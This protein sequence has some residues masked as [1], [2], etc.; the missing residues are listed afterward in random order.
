MNELFGDYV[1]DA[2]QQRAGFPVWVKCADGM[3]GH[4]DGW[5][6]PGAMHVIHTD[7]KG[8]WAIT[9]MPDEHTLAV[10]RPHGGRYPQ[11]AEQWGMIRVGSF[12]PLDLVVKAL[13]LAVPPGSPPKPTSKRRGCPRCGPGCT[14]CKECCYHEAFCQPPEKKVQH[15]E[16]LAPPPR[17]LWNVDPVVEKPEPI[18]NHVSKTRRW[19]RLL[20]YGPTSGP[21]C[22]GSCSVFDDTAHKTHCG[23]V[24]QS[25]LENAYLVEA[26]NAITLRPKLARRL[27]YDWSI[28]FS[29]FA[30]RLFKN[31]T[32]LCVEV[33]DWVPVRDQP[34]EADDND[35]PFC[36]YSEHFP[37]VLWPSLVEKAYAK[38]STIRDHGVGGDT[39]NTGG[40]ESLGGGGRV[41]EALAD[42]TGGV[43]SSFSTRDVA[44]DRLFIYLYELQR[45]C[46]FV[47]R[48]HLIHC[49]KR[50]VQLDPFSHYS[51]NRAAHHEGQGFVQVF[52][53]SPTGVHTAGLDF[54]IAPDVF[55]S[56]YPEKV[57]D[58]FFWLSVYDF[59][60][61]FDTIFECRLT[62]SP[63]VGLEGMPPSRLPNARAPSPGAPLK[64]DPKFFGRPMQPAMA[65][66]QSNLPAG[67]PMA[68]MP[69]PGMPMPT[70][71][72]PAMPMAG[73]PVPGIP[74]PPVGNFGPP[75]SGPPLPGMPVPEPLDVQP[76]FFEHVFAIDET[77]TEHRPPEFGVVLP[78]IPCEVVATVEQTCSRISQ[79]GPDRRPYTAILLKVYEQVDGNYYSSDLIC[80]SGWVPARDSM[81][82]FKSLKGGT[83]KII[84]EMLKG[85]KC[86]RLIFRCY[87]SV[88]S[89]M[90]TAAGSTRQHVLVAPEGPPQ[91]IKWTFV[92]CVPPE[93]LERVDL[94]MAPVDD[95]DTL[96]K[97]E[98]ERGEKCTVM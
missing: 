66:L 68:G 60:F 27:F 9:R 91:A 15:E 43:A 65:P 94:P 1:L 72:M 78:G 36:C 38:A 51:V 11:L 62:N 90:I 77:V 54:L 4:G 55:A 63:D 7:A 45:D 34:G 20:S 85:E 26:L 44:P 81:V 57:E 76:V 52:C 32:W 29:V 58:G 28:E 41:D 98:A 93:R 73:M 79:V 23:R 74:I 25:S 21:G 19:E 92:G 86:D 35:V 22:S 61:Y 31:G 2:H 37:D 42:L 48:V 3:P 5:S 97:K 6:R 14:G 18:E 89:A 70:M 39:I 30:V 67:I 33:D 84:A 64:L 10:S 95:L 69:M 88:S 50:G 47:C 80:K 17:L 12:M 87:T 59:H 83:F 13:S 71:P 75:P 46:L 82:A 16:A 96:R 40:W 56:I 8:R 53:A 24:F 49:I